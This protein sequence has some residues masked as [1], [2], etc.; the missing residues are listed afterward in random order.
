MKKEENKIA[1]TVID[2]N[3][4]LDS[5][6]K[7]DALISILTAP[8][9]PKK[10]GRKKSTETTV[11]KEDEKKVESTTLTNKPKNTKKVV[12]EIKQEEEK[13]IPEPEVPVNEELKDKLE[14]IVGEPR[15][16]VANENF[17]NAVEI[18]EE[19]H[20]KR[21]KKAVDLEPDTV[22]YTVNTNLDSGLTADEVEHRNLYGHV[23]R[24]NSGSSK[25]IKAIILSNVITVFNLLNFAIGGWL[26]SIGQPNQ[27]FFLII[28]TANI[29]I[30]IFQEIR[31]K[32]TIDQLSL[33]SAPSA[34]VIRDGEE[35]EIAVSDIVLGDIMLL[36]AG[37]QIC[38]DSILR[39]G[40]LEVNESLLTGESDAIVKKPGDVLFSGSFVVSG[41]AKVQVSAVGNDN[42]IEKLT[43]E[44]KKYIKP[45]SDLLKS[46]KVV[47]RTV[48]VLI[49]ILGPLYFLENI[50][51]SWGGGMEYGGNSGAVATTAGAII[52]MIPSGLFL[53]TSIALAVGVIR[54]GQ[55]NT[56]VQELYCIEMLARVDCLC[57]DK[58]GTI[59]DG[60][61]SV[62]GVV[63]YKNDTG[64]AVKQ[65]ISAHL[66]ALNDDN[67]TSVALEQKFGR[68]KK[69]KTVATIPFSSAR[70]YSAAQFEKYGTFA[71]GAPEF[72][73]KKGYD[74]ISY[75][76][77]R[78][79]CQGYRVLLLAK[80]TGP[81]QDGELTG[82]VIPVALILIE[83]TIRPEAIS[84]IEYFKNNGVSVRVISGD[85]P[86][87][88]SK[89]SER[90]GI[91]NAYKYI[92]LDGL[93]DKEVIKA[94][95]KYTVFG[96]VTPNQKRL[97]VK[98]LKANGHTVA[99]TGDG[100]NDILALKESDCSI[101]MAS[102]SEAARNVS[103]LVL[104]DSNFASMP[105]VV[106]EGR[107][108]INNVQKVASL[109]LTKTIFST[110]LLAIVVC[111]RKTYPIV[112]I[113]L[114]M[115][116]FLVIGCPSF[117]LALEPNSSV[118]KGKFLPNVLKNALPG[119]LV[120]IIYALIV[121]GLEGV[122]NINAME[123]STII[124]VSATFTAMMVLF[125]VCRPFNGLRTVLFLAMFSIFVIVLFG[126]P[127]KFQLVPLQSLITYTD[128]VVNGVT[129]THI[130]ISKLAVLI[131]MVVV[132][133]P[134]MIVFSEGVSW[135][136]A[137]IRDFLKYMG[138][139]Y[140]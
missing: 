40:S 125:R 50:L 16:L 140:K 32:K 68:T 96:R 48:G 75:D 106:N 122:L 45:K 74:E 130:D 114:M 22:D 47:I 100:V 112:P 86:L 49:V 62:R 134:L 81:I 101:A 21:A 25:T 60:T 46:L 88:V 79:A 69:I 113:Q 126:I 117:V 136:K 19:K 1:E 57:L 73:M 27:C 35:N 97:L 137:R 72:I 111:L 139:S 66:N 29:V 99:M 77:E 42:Y 138:N 120:I 76:V 24:T 51:P 124:V 36:S 129:S 84:T 5:E 2:E 55:N 17:F 34:I 8:S 33:I 43:G 23:N 133:Y 10:R 89:V 128:V 131:I 135:V 28:V 92:S 9:E 108:V 3:P 15:A 104:L 71:L 94:A 118:V 64:L 14:G 37:K 82:E 87:T 4:A 52:G 39:E 18:E 132:A 127:D 109:F 85:N 116:D 30:G 95:T 65:I 12:E 7:T 123:R 11:L 56:L 31:A 67:L 119:A 61:M 121:Y 53:L 83:D 20:K 90:A 103:H 63:E 26:L 58:T 110:L 102:G 78:N 105:K 6:H 59:T 41:N 80:I 54:L 98:T 38:S 13:I 91:E 107:R 93:S 44:A 115:I 70:K